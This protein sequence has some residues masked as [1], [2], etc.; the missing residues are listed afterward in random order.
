MVSVFELLNPDYTKWQSAYDAMLNGIYGTGQGV[1]GS[2]GMN[3][4]P[5]RPTQYSNAG[6][7][8]VNLETFQKYGR[9]NPVTEYAKA[10]SGL[11]TQGL[12]NEDLARFQMPTQDLQAAA[13]GSGVDYNTMIG[14]PLTGMAGPVQHGQLGQAQP[15]TQMSRPTTMGVKQ[16][17]GMFF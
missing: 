5:P 13:R 17:R 4:A 9:L 8:P 11:S 12:T 10:T 3:N 14:K 6:R 16:T 1:G 15:L 2:I 7:A